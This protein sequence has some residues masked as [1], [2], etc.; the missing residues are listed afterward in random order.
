M[1]ESFDVHIVSA[2]VGALSN[3]SRAIFLVPSEGG[4]ITVLGCEVTQGGAGTQSLYLVDLGS[5]GTAV[6]SGGT[7]ASLGSAVA[8]ANTPAAMTVG[9]T[10]DGFVDAGHYVGVKED[11]VGAANAVT[12][13]SVSYVMGK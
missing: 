6:A 8:V 4:G 9:T 10:Y 1:S 12:I 5:G 7:V 11:N 2:N 13:V 3:A